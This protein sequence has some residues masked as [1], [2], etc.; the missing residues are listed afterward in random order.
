V[1]VENKR[2]TVKFLNLLVSE[3]KFNSRLFGERKGSEKTENKK[4]K[5][6]FW[7][8]ISQICLSRKKA[9]PGLWLELRHLSRGLERS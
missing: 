2:P 4:K 5:A 1:L 6:D 8:I 7:F 3:S 9:F